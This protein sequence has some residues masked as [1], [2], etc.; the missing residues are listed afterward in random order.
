M[1][2]YLFRHGAA[3]DRG[4]DGRDASRRLTD[5]GQSEVRRA[6]ALGANGRMSPGLV[7]SSPY[8]R[9]VETAR[10]AADA[11]GYRGQILTSAAL[12]PDSS[13]SDVWSEIRAHSGESS[14]LVVGHEPLLSETAAWLLG[15]TRVIVE[16]PKAA[17]ARI[18]FENLGPTPA[19]VLRWLV[20][21]DLRPSTPDAG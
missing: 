20:T 4:P 6:L 5:E 7:L 3:E 17:L 21:P 2:L 15:S 13:P 19:G 1:E 11:L 10:V 8:V 9:A 18:D 16:F 14:I 12:E